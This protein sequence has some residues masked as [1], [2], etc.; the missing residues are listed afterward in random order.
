MPD[1][2]QVRNLA[3]NFWFFNLAS[4]PSHDSTFILFFPYILYAVPH[5]DMGTSLTPHSY[6]KLNFIMVLVC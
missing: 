3:C 1:S 6:L 2:I 5:Q 4:K